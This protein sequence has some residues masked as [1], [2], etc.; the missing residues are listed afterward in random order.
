MEK[1]TR[2]LDPHFQIERLE[3]RHVALKE[4][5]AELDSHRY[6]TVAEQL[7]VHELKKEKLAT[8]DLLVGLRRRVD[9]D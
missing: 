9:S 2:K 1:I 6:L 8:K 5:I 7:L 4:Q 3:K